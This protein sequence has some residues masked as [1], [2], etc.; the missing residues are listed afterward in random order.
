MIGSKQKMLKWVQ[1][2][3]RLVDPL[4]IHQMMM[5]SPRQHLSARGT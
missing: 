2:K 4:P 1:Q 5:L 3:E